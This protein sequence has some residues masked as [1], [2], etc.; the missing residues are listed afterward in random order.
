LGVA[1]LVAGW[2][3]V[4]VD[5]DLIFGIPV[6]GFYD[7]LAQDS[8]I[9]VGGSVGGF[10]VAFDWFGVGTPGAQRFEIVDPLTFA[11]LDSG[12]T[13]IPE[14]GTIELLAVGLFVVLCSFGR[15]KARAR[16]SITA[17]VNNIE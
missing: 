17:P 13:G 12:L 16:Q 6:D 2:D 9:A 3:Q 4:T 1:T 10:S 8:G 11:V 14:P 7:A 5:H 15:K